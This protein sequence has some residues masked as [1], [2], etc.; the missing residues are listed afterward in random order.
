MKT[1]IAFLEA[2]YANAEGWVTVS[3][4]NGT[5]DWKDGVKTARIGADLSGVLCDGEEERYFRVQPQASQH[6]RGEGN[7][8]GVVALIAD[9]D[10]PGS[11]DNKKLAPFTDLSDV[12][13]FCRTHVPVPVS[14]VVLSGH[15]AHAYWFIDEPLEPD[16][17]KALL[18]RFDLNL[19]DRAMTEGKQLDPMQDLARVFRLPGSVNAKDPDALVPVTVEHLYPQRRYSLD[20]FD[21]L[22]EIGI[23]TIDIG[24]NKVEPLDMEPI[25]CTLASTRACQSNR[26]GRRCIS[27][28]PRS[29]SGPAERTGGRTSTRLS[30][31][32]SGEN[33]PTQE[34]SP[35]DQ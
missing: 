28:Q 10:F 18:V 3:G 33:R 9:F 20:D 30:R 31:I 24:A 8:A 34:R 6:G 35:S 15:G 7:T 4:I 27:T 5:G 14:A 21:W 29:T 1:P 26:L 16:E 19:R 2:L 25:S 23:N 12:T 13:R 22:P 11:S 32:T 17:G